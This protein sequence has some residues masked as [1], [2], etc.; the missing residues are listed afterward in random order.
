M[1][2][3]RR[4][5]IRTLFSGIARPV[6]ASAAVLSLALPTAALSGSSVAGASPASR[7]SFIYNT[8]PAKNW[9]V[10]IGK[11]ALSSPTI[12]EIDGVRA[13]VQATLSGYVHVFN[14]TTGRELPGWPQPVDIAAGRPT[15]VDSTPTVAYL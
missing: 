2:A 4:R 1:F 8:Y 7:P 13:V 14:A 6:F 5:G 9:I 10:P 15:A 11:V 3:E 12:A